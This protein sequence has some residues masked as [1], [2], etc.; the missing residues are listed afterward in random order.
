MENAV[1][2]DIRSLKTVLLM[3]LVFP[4]KH[5]RMQNKLH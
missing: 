1:Y 3:S 5:R 4:L 2:I